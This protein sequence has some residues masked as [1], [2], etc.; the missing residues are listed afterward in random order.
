[1]PSKKKS[2]VEVLPPEEIRPTRKQVVA[3]KHTVVYEAPEI[4]D[5]PIEDDEEPQPEESNEQEYAPRQPSFRTKI[6]EKFRQRGIGVDETLNLRIDRLP[7]FE[8]NGFGGLKAEKEFCGIIP[9]TEKFFDGD[10][11]LIEIQRRYGPGEYWLTVRHKNAIVS[12]WRERLGGFPIAPIA[13]ASS[14]PGQP[15]QIIYQQPM[16]QAQAQSAPIRT[17]KE[18][19]RDVAEMIKLVDTI[20]GPARDENPAPQAPITDPDTILISSLASNDKF[21]DRISGGLV[22]KLIGKNGTEDD[23]SPWAVAMELVKTG[24]AAQ[25]VKTFM[26]SLFNGFSNMIPGRQNNGQAQMATAPTQMDNGQMRSPITQGMVQG[27]GAPHTHQEGTGNVPTTEIRQ[28]D[29]PTATPEE[30]ALAL[31]INHCSRKLSPKITYRE[32]IDME[33]R[34]DAMLNQHAMQ[35]GQILSNQIALYLDIFAD[36]TSDEAL[37]VVKTLPNGEQVASLPHA[38]DW[39]EQLQKLIRESQQEGGE[40]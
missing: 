20:R 28:M 26:D 1:M 30:Q 2:A 5:I 40:E 8:Q 31:V 35:T 13:V 17:V 7:L 18:E 39:T 24:Q 11:Y 33:Q 32:L 21:M 23:P 38:K 36:M 14:E 15:P 10:E 12:S 34:L 27:Q 9:C 6:R 37:E 19:M 16:G 22:G 29:V 3:A 25:I 4:V